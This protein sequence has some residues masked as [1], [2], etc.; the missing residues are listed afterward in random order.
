MVTPVQCLRAAAR[1]HDHILHLRV[2]DLL[3]PVEVEQAQRLHLLR[4][5][6]GG[7]GR[8]QLHH[9]GVRVGGQEVDG[10]LPR[11]VVGLVLF[12]CNDKVPAEELKV[13][14]QR[15]HAAAAFVV[16]LLARHRQVPLHALLPSRLSPKLQEWF[17]GEMMG[18]RESCSA[19]TPTKP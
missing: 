12:R 17:L 13:H 6:A 2:D 3:L 16:A 10:A 5:A 11:T 7:G 14:L 8:R 15:V 19:L 1:L 9:V 18:G 4:G